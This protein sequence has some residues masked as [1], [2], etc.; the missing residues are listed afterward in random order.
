MRFVDLALAAPLACLLTPFAAAQSGQAQSDQE[1]SS[2]RDEIRQI[3]RE[4][5]RAALREAH[6]GAA[7]ATPTEKAGK[8]SKKVSSDHVI[9]L[10]QAHVVTDDAKVG[11]LSL[12]MAHLEDLLGKLEI[13]I[14]G[15]KVAKVRGKGK[16]TEHS[17][18]GAMVFQVAGDDD[19]KDEAKKP[20]GLTFSISN[21][22]TGAIEWKPMKVKSTNGGDGTMVFEVVGGDDDDKDEAKKPQGMTYSISEG[23]GGVIDLRSDAKGKSKPK[24]VK[25]A[26]GGEGT[27]VLQMGDDEKGEDNKPMTFSFTE[28]DE[29]TMP[30]ANAKTQVKKTKKAKATTTTEGKTMVF[31][32]RCEDGKCTLEP[33]NGTGDGN[34]LFVIKTDGGD[35]NTKVQAVGGNKNESKSDCC[36]SGDSCCDAKP[37]ATSVEAQPLRIRLAE[38]MELKLENSAKPDDFKPD[39]FKVESVKIDAQP[40]RVRRVQTDTAKDPRNI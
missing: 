19:D 26:N 9:H 39:D 32:L 38:P 7:V 30:K 10:G 18:E 37:E 13:A 33:I 15:D 28:G 21:G 25:S 6:G 31:Q 16:P 23:K 24:K 11:E 22:E 8:T 20:Q 40:I 17:G 4:E 34:N 14:D 3:V 29:G 27:V 1:R 2:L 36:C 12:E 35:G 5:I